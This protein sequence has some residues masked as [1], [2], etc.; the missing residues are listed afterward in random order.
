MEALESEQQRRLKKCS[1]DR[2]RFTLA[3]AGKSPDEIAGLDR[4]QLLNAVA[5]TIVTQAEKPIFDE[6][7]KFE[8]E[9]EFDASDEKTCELSLRQ[10]EIEL[11]E[12][13]RQERLQER[14]ERAQLEMDRR[15]FENEKFER[16]MA[17]RQSEFQR[18]VA[19]DTETARRN[20]STQSR[21]KMCWML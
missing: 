8:S 3:K 15:R 5:E 12:I 10:R 1:S 16:E 19:R 9:T 18:L 21:L 14:A 2:L 13:E 6:L 11:R 17:I 4:L 20:E 7:V